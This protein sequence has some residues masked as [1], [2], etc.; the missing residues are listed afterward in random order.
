MPISLV[1]V[2]KY[3]SG[4]SHQKQ[5]LQRLQQEIESA[6]PELL[7]DTSD[8]ARLWRNQTAVKNDFLITP[9]GIGPAKI[10][11]TYGQI[12]QALGADYTYVDVSPFMVDLAGVAVMR[13][14]ISGFF[15]GRA[16]AFYLAYPSSAALTDST[17]INLFITA[18]PK[19][20][21]A[22]GTGPGT[23]LSAAVKDYGKAT[24]SFNSDG[25]SREFVKFERTPDNLVF[26]AEALTHSFAGDYSVPDAIAVPDCV[27]YDSETVTQATYRYP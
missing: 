23:L 25:E 11:S 24:L 4:V 21:T 1:D 18:N 26:R 19:Y 6:N 22:Q 5:A 3:Y 17:K 20:Q 9:E 7:S 13:E 16:I 2:A 10:G 12:K 27:R 8:F 15:P 14:G